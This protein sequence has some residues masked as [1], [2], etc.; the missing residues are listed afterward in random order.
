MFKYGTIKAIPATNF[1]PD[2]Q[3]LYENKICTVVDA[4]EK[5]V[6]LLDDTSC[7][8]EPSDLKQLVVEYVEK[9]LIKNFFSSKIKEIVTQ[10]PLK[11]SHWKLAV[12]LKLVDSI[13]MVR[14]ETISLNLDNWTNITELSLEKGNQLIA[15]LDKQSYLKTYSEKEHLDEMIEFGEH[16]AEKLGYS[17]LQMIGELHNYLEEKN[18]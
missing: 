16:V 11:Y 6:Q 10:F 3:V 8:Y 4:N 17:G 9:K 5:G 15:R 7:L 1:E 13:D 14:F 12:K 18:K 2:A